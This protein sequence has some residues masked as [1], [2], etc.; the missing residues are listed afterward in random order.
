MEKDILVPL[1]QEEQDL[2]EIEKKDSILEKLER[3]REL[4]RERQ[5][6][7]RRANKEKVR[8]LNKKRREKNSINRRAELWAKK[9]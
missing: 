8:E 7:W 6:K 1:Q 9:L 3:A 2:P 4:N 5:R